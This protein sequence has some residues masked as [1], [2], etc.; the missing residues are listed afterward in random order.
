MRNKLLHSLFLA[1]AVGITYLFADAWIGLY[2]ENNNYDNANSIVSFAIERP[3]VYRLLVPAIARGLMLLTSLP[4]DIAL[5]IVI[6]L[7]GIGLFYSVRYLAMA[8][9]KD[10]TRA[11]ISAILCVA[12]TVIFCQL[13]G[14]VYDLATTM[15]FALL[16]GLL[17]R[18]RLGLYYIVFPIAVLNRETTALLIPFFAIYFIL[19]QT[20]RR[21]ILAGVL[22]QCTVFVVIYLLVTTVFADNP[23]ELFVWNPAEVIGMYAAYPFVTLALLTIASIA[24]YI[25]FRGW[26]EKPAFLRIA[27]LCLLPIQLILH[28]LMGYAFEV[29]VFAE[30][31][32]VIVLLVYAGRKTSLPG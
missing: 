4:A 7:S 32:P 26:I 12:I 25:V 20:P 24:L 22:Y 5:V 3:Y 14:K 28:L 19:Y 15:F 16:L 17:A 13:N 29:R 1:T 6:M 30:G 27:F 9:D 23:G 2:G 8:F 31:F 18:G 21:H 10:D 11:S